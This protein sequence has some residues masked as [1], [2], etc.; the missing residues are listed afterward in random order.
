M[1]K[2]LLKLC[3][4][5][6]GGFFLS[7]SD[8]TSFDSAGWVAN[9]DFAAGTKTVLLPS[10]SGHFCVL[11]GASTENADDAGEW[12][13]CKLMKSPSSDR[14]ILQAILSKNGDSRVLCEAHCFNY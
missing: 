14:W 1:T 7:S 9:Q 3:V 10:F 4:L 8:A 2:N 5:A 6:V 11:T 13:M 12:T